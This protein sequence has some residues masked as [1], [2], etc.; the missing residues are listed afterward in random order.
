M[1]SS[2]FS[3][4][5]SVL[6]YLFQCRVALLESIR[7]IRTGEADAVTIESLDDIAFEKNGTPTELLQT[8]HHSTACTLT[9]ASPELWKTLRIWIEF[10]STTETPIGDVALFL[11]STSKAPTDSIASYLGRANRNVPEAIRLLQ[12]TATATTSETNRPG[13]EAFRSLNSSAQQALIAAIHVITSYDDIQDVRDSLRKELVLNVREQHLEYFIDRVEGWWFHQCV[14]YLATHSPDPISVSGIH[15]QIVALGE[16]FEEQNLPVDLW[17]DPQPDD[18]D[19]DSRVFVLQLRQI[20]LTNRAIEQAVRN[21][22]R[23][24]VNRSKWNR[25]DLLLVGELG[26]YEKKLVEE[27]EQ[28]F[29]LMRTEIGE[30]PQ[31]DVARSNGFQLYQALSFTKHIPIRPKVSEVSI[32]R[33]SLHMLADEQRIGWHCSFKERLEQLLGVATS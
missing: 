16:Q 7:R 2:L 14:E 6:G 25:E 13:A 29:E 11:L 18:V 20:G 28:L 19:S 31:D 22:Y 24:F 9:N 5:D 8:K 32:Y 15:R 27:W 3:A 12:E 4:S 26:Q 30:S 23:A 21:Y 1:S 10:H 33:G 17:D